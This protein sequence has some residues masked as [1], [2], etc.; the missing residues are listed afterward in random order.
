[1]NTTRESWWIVGSFSLVTQMVSLSSFL[2]VIAW[3]LVL[4][5]S[6]VQF[7]RICRIS[8]KQSRK[9]LNARTH[10]KSLE[11]NEGMC[12][13]SIYMFAEVLFA[14]IVIYFSLF[15]SLSLQLSSRPSM[16]NR[17]KLIYVWCHI[18][19][20]YLRGLNVRSNH[21]N[22][23]RWELRDEQVEATKGRPWWYS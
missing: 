19:R 2:F 3:R 1:M 7:C 4:L 14:L 15:L 13:K 6:F 22:L 9:I 17:K 11:T 10:F 21:K 12:H 8:V 23:E 20:I 16:A 18:K 5:V